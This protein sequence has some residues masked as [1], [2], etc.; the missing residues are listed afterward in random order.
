MD[1]SFVITTDTS[2]DLPQEYIDQHQLNLVTLYFI[3]DGVTYGY[4]C[5]QNMDV[6]EFYQKMRD[7]SAPKTQ[8]ADPEHIK[9]VFEPLL[10]QGKDILHL[11]FSSGLSGTTN[12]CRIAAEDLPKV[13]SK[14]YKANSTRRGS[15]IGLAVADEIVSLHGGSL[16][17]QSQEGVGTTVSIHLPLAN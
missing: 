17:L 1:T 16:D 2:S 13:K 5:P 12:S 6:K 10:R 3:V 14:F 4:N 15:G 11:S 7:G 8:Q 9:T